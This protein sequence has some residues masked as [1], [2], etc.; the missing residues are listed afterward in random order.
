MT[1]AEM[2]D[3]I[4]DL[5]REVAEITSERDEHVLALE[6]LE[7]EIDSPEQVFCRRCYKPFP[8]IGGREY[9]SRDCQL[10]GIQQPF[11]VLY[12]QLHPQWPEV[13]GTKSSL[14]T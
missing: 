4:V 8:S 11:S 6:A 5:E 7:D 10:F 14:L 13:R 3:R 1:S 2:E 9:C 12:K